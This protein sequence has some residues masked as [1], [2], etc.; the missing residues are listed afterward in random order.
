MTESTQHDSRLI[1]SY[2][3]LRKLIG[4][5][6]FTFPFVLILGGFFTKQDIQSSISYY[7]HTP[8]RDIFVAVLCIVAAFLL[9]YKGYEKKDEIAGNI[10]GLS[11]IG[12]A[13]IPTTIDTNATSTQELLG[14][15]HLLFAFCYFATIAYFCLFLFTKSNQADLGYRKRQRNVI[16]RSCGY[17]I[18][19]CLVLIGIYALVLPENI[20]ALLVPYK[21]LFWLES[22]AIIAFGFSW[23]CKGEAI[24]KD[25]V[26]E[27]V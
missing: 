9:A 15:I 23:L 11:A 26:E 17:I 10:A 4:L 18:I 5:L 27:K 14:N 16:Y 8:M 12:V 22:I 2:L 7:Y 3:T 19:A 21:P 6:G 24:F 20:K 25:E 1:I 13:M